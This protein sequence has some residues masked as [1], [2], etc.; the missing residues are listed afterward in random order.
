MNE[1]TRNPRP[2]EARCSRGPSTQEIVHRDGRRVPA[3]LEQESYR[4]LG[5]EDISIDRYTSQAFH[6]LEMERLWP[7]VWQWA[8]REEH[9]PE[10][11]DY[12]VYDIGRTSIM[13][14]RSNEGIKAY[15]NSCLHRSTKFRPSGSDGT[16]SELRCPYHGWTWTLEGDLKR[17][18]CAWDFPHV[19][20]GKFHLPEVRVG[21]WGGFVFVNMDENAPSLEEYMAPLAEH[22]EGWDLSK[23]YIDIHIE[24]ELFANWKTA[25]EAFMENYHTQ[26]AHPQLMYGNG[27]ENTQYDLCSDHVS[28]FYSTSGVSSPH[29]DKP[30]T[31]QE[32]V[33]SMLVGDRT[34]LRDELT[35]RDG[36]TARVVMARVLRKILGDTYKADLSSYTDTEILDVMEYMLFPNMTLFPGLSLPMIYRFRPLDSDPNRSLFEILFLRPVPDDGP[37]PVPARPVR[38]SETDSYTSIPGIDPALGHVYDQD[39]DNLRSQ[40]EGFLTTR[41]KGQTLANYQEIRIRH[42][43]QVIDKYLAEGA[44]P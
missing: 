5:D 8:C 7:R 20:P 6:G 16:V 14:V 29:L 26:E 17:V 2:G 31:E 19:E 36:E 42:F 38:L 28:R 32:L 44:S 33:N 12:Y 34:L 39:T 27:D 40:Q 24:K 18:P 15:Y 1:M 11:G 3:I 21:L 35:L 10:I 25:Q 43:E 13:V 41:K 37:R 4:F 23:R 22:F 30:M 9:I